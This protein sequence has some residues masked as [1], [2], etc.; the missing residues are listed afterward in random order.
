MY[1]IPVNPS[2]EVNFDDV[3]RYWYNQ[4]TCTLHLDDRQIRGVSLKI[5][6]K[7]LVA[8]TLYRSHLGRIF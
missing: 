6:N 4:D 8:I 7:F 3:N 5:Y 2:V 1:T